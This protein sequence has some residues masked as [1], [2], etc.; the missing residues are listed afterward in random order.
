[1]RD[2]IKNAHAFQHEGFSFIAVTLP[3]VELLFDLSQRLSRSQAILELL[4]MDSMT[5]SPDPLLLLLFQLQ[6]SFLVSHEYT[7]HVHRHVAPEG[8]DDAWTEFAQG[9]TSGGMDR[10]AQ[11]LDADAYA[12]YLVLGNFIRGEGRRGALAQ[13]GRQELGSLEADALLLNYFFLSVMSL[14]SALWPGNMR[15]ASTRDFTHPPAPLRIEYAIRVAKMWSEQNQSVPQAWF[16]AERFQALFRAAVNA[17]GGATPQQWDEHVR[18]LSSEEASEYNASLF[19]RFEL[20][21]AGKELSPEPAV[22]R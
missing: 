17:I 2:D 15:I 6:M 10:Q 9:A 11:E 19:E 1:M 14:F 18:F 22:A 13:I 4:E 12:I 21:R 5:L 8:G 3:F 16:G 7:H 20:L